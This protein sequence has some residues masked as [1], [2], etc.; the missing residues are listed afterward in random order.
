MILTIQPVITVRLVPS[1]SALNR[2]NR[3]A[4]VCSDL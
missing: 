3:V 2:Q 1:A 4:S